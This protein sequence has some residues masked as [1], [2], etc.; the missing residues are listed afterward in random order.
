V[1]FTQPSH[2]DLLAEGATLSARLVHGRSRIW[3]R[4]RGGKR[5]MAVP[6]PQ[7]VNDIPAI[8]A[9]KMAHPNSPT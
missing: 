8:A 2:T 7:E 5:I 3:F 6:Y 9:R 1:D 4:C